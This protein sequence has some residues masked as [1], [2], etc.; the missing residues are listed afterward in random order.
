MEFPDTLKGG[1]GNDCGR[2]MGDGMWYGGGQLELVGRME[3]GSG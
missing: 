2:M 3:D 1:T